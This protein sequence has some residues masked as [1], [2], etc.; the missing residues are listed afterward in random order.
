MGW[1]RILLFGLLGLMGWIAV[2][3]S[4]QPSGDIRRFDPV[5]VGQLETGM[6]R[7]YY[8]RRPVALFRQLAA[9]LRAQFHL[10]FWQSYVASFYASRAAF[11]FKDGKQRSDYERALPD[12][13]VYYRRILSANPNTVTVA[14]LELEWWIIH[15]ERAT[16]PAGALEMSLA[17]LQ[18]AIYAV[19]RERL[20]EHAAFR[21]RAMLLR[22]QQAGQGGVTEADW[23]SIEGML[24]KSWSSLERALR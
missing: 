5:A 3:L 7:S 12:L 17:E 1:R 15:R 22:D 13:E 9:T 10:P 23:K 21:A 8:D 20:E 4:R 24:V 6:W 2:D 11:R 14:R 19:P 18:A 16:Q